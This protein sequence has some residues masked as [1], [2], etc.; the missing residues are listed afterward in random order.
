M[1]LEPYETTHVGHGIAWHSTANGMNAHV[2]VGGKRVKSFKNR[3]TA[4]TDAQRHA[5]DLWLKAN[6]N[7]FGHGGL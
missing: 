1:S 6:L 3:E 2:T 4:H 5:T 7:E